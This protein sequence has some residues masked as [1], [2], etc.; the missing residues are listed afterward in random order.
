MGILRPGE[1][2][3]KQD[4]VQPLQGVDGLMTELLRLQQL[5]QSAVKLL[6]L[7]LFNFPRNNKHN[8]PDLISVKRYDNT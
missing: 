1:L 7:R 4:D 2:G 6:Q 3:G 8:T 5:Q